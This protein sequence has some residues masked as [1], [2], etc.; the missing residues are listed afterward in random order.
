MFNFLATVL[1]LY[2]KHEDMIPE[3]LEEHASLIVVKRMNLIR[4][5]FMS[6]V[7]K[8]RIRTHELLASEIYFISLL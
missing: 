4:G 5:T 2:T 6:A 1:N 3:S 7:C 8:I